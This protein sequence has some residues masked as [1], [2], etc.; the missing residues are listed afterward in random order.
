M[1]ALLSQEKTQMASHHFRQNGCCSNDAHV[2]NLLPP[3]CDSCREPEVSPQIPSTSHDAFDKFAEPDISPRIGDEYQAKLP[4]FVESYSRNCI[5]SE[6]EPHPDQNFLIGLPIL[7]TW[8][9][10][11]QSHAPG[12]QSRSRTSLD[13]KNRVVKAEI[14]E[15][16]HDLPTAEKMSKFGGRGYILVPGLVDACW[17]A[18]EKDSFLLG[19]YIFEKKFVEVRRFVGT[20]ETGAILSFYYGSFYGSREYRRWSDC[21]KAK[22]KKGIYGQRIFSGVRLQELLN[23]VLFGLTVECRD[24]ILE[25]TKSFGDEKISL[26]DYVFTLKT[27]LGIKNLVGAVG[28]GKGKLDLTEMPLESSRS[29]PTRHEIPTGKALCS[30]TTDE[31]IKFLSPDYRLSK[32][33]SNDIFWEAVWPRLLARGWHSEQP[34]NQGFVRHCLVFLM[35]GIKKFSRRKLMKGEHYFDSV[36]DVLSRVAKEPELINLDFEEEEEG[37]SNKKEEYESSSKKKSE[38]HCY[39]QPRIP[40]KRNIHFMKFTVVDT[41]LPCGRIREL[42]AFPSEMSSTFTARGRKEDSGEDISDEKSNESNSIDILSAKSYKKTALVLPDFKNKKHLREN[43]RTKKVPRARKAKRDNVDT[44]DPFAKRCRTLTIARGQ[45]ETNV[46]NS[47]IDEVTEN[48]SSQASQ[49]RDIM[50]TAGSSGGGRGQDADNARSPMLIDLN[51]PQAPPD[52]ET[53]E[54]GRSGASNWPETSCLL[55][56][57]GTEARP[58]QPLNLNP[59]RLSTRN[60]PPTMRVLE[61]VADGYLTISKKRKVK[62]ACSNENLSSRPARRANRVVGPNEPAAHSPVAP[63]IG[64]SQ[65]NGVPDSGNSNMVVE[66]DQVP[67]EHRFS[68]SA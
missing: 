37:F 8:I 56:T 58:E 36:T 57:L 11:L 9:N 16:L 34:K 27:M 64:E 42:R 40:K 20:K 24:S 2:G 12:P 31:I 29:N 51:L 38:K 26:A 62:S 52:S 45:E 65:R 23:R 6:K 25:V 14:V 30:L 33:R 68:Y 66:A 10:I 46:S 1:K 7:L 32:T 61:A 28:I 35:P 17:N 22:G 19:L 53:V 50:S 43:N 60:R 3:E 21:R 54:M 18:L 41:S 48:V 59:R 63:E 13:N 39:L 55:G 47:D 15:E 44:A 49:A 5:K 4:P 67:P